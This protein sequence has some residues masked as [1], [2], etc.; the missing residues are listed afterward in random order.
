MTTS[1]ASGG[2][3]ARD[4]KV[5]GLT[6]EE[7]ILDALPTLEPLSAIQPLPTLGELEE[8]EPVGFMGSLPLLRDLEEST[9]A[10]QDDENAP[11]SP[12]DGE[13]FGPSSAE[14]RR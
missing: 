3:K 14:V 13:G 6:D 12:S 1:N 2:D 11:A 10:A 5:Q 8:F 9:E 4:T 7:H